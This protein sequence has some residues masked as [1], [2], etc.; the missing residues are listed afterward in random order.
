[1]RVMHNA[2]VIAALALASCGYA[3]PPG[4]EVVQP[5]AWLEG[6]ETVP[7]VWDLRDDLP[8]SRTA[9]CSRWLRDV[10]VFHANERE[11]IDELHACPCVDTPSGRSDD[12]RCVN[13]DRCIYGTVTMWGDTRDAF[14]AIFLAP[15]E[16]P[17]GHG[18]TV[19]HELGHLLARC[20]GLGADS[21]HTNTAIW[22]GDGVVWNGDGICGGTP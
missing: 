5:H 2:L 6:V 10:R 11:W 16:P 19:D 12:P 1:M 7:I 18:G 8:T 4:V 13:T 9:R 15:R 21:A 17:E 20:S 14:P 22:G 3:T